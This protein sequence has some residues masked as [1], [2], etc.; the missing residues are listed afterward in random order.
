MATQM[1]GFAESARLFSVTLALTNRCT[2][3]CWHCY[4]AGRSQTDLPLPTWQRLASELQEL[5]A[6]VV[7]LTGGEPLLR[8]DL[9]EIV[10]AFDDRSC[11][12]LGTTGWGLTAARA[13]SLREA[14]AFA[15]GISLDSDLEPEHDR[16]R[17]K[18]GA[19]REALHA[20]RIC[21]EAGLYPY[22]VTVARRELLERERFLAFLEFAGTAG[23]LEVH[24]LEPSATGRLAG[25]TDTPLKPRERARIIDYQREVARRQ[26][27]PILS[28]FNYL[29]AADAFGC[30]AGLTHLYVD[31]SGEVCPCNLV[32]LSFGNVK[33][34]PFV[35]I[36]D[37]MG[38]YFRLPRPGCVGRILA[39]RAK[40]SA[41]PT[42]FRTSCELCEKYLPKKHALPAFFR[43]RAEAQ[44]SVGTRELA[45]SYD[46]IHDEYDGFWVVE[47]GAAVRELVERLALSGEERVFEAGCGTGFG[48]ALLVERL[49]RG[50][51]KAV[52]LSEGM[53]GRAK[54]RLALAGSQVDFHCADALAELT[55]ERGLDTVFSSWVLGYIRL[56][57]FFEATARALRKGGRLGLVVHKENSPRR[58]LELFFELA[59]RDPSVM[60]RQVS[61]DFPRDAQHLR[62]ELAARGLE[63]EQLWEGAAVF[64]YDSAQAVLEHLLKSGAGTVFYEAIDPERRDA[65]TAEFLRLLAERNGLGRFEVRHEYLGCVARKP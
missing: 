45:A 28:S 55:S 4:N 24:L 16:L 17:A 37:R 57:P 1:G 19:F 51:V 2:F 31:G 32:P 12:N 9:E 43:V 42:P 49:A 62:D 8:P 35:S 23:A 29:E 27:L 14:G 11:V 59:A 7:T 48:T 10:R 5:G 36:L 44:A 41:S 64:C 46:E 39:P 56:A 60:L 20:L 40:G 15:V 26:D 33:D 50:R 25:D 52:D 63:V 38:E 3:D 30:G 6:T 53:L 65:L 34:T 58:E 13:R 21:G 54:A 18:Q 47:A 61:F 22:V